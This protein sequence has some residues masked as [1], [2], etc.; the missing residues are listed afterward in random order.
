MDTDNIIGLNA[1][2]A[3]TALRISQRGPSGRLAK[4]E[5]IIREKGV[6]LVPVPKTVGGL[7]RTA[8]RL[9]EK[10]ERKLWYGLAEYNGRKVFVISR[11]KIEGLKQTS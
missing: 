7:Y 8:K 3:K 5:A 6:A 4:L 2:A 10:M 1:E 11:V 9:A